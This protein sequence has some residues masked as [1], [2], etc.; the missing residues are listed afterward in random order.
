MIPIATRD[1]SSNTK[2]NDIQTSW[3]PRVDI[4]G[5]QWP[6]TGLAR[7]KNNLRMILPT[8]SAVG[9]IGCINLLMTSNGTHFSKAAPRNIPA[10]IDFRRR[11][12]SRRAANGMAATTD[13]YLN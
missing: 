5:S 2:D 10:R 4:Q 7:L 6:A 13:L 11:K 12:P 8:L 9:L 1:G 3:C